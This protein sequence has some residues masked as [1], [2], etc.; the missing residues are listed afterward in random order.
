MKIVVAG[1]SGGIGKAFV[2]SL[3][4][5]PHVEKIIATCNSHC[6]ATDH[7]NVTWQRLNLADEAAVRDWAQQLDDIDW[8]I[9][10]AGVLHTPANGPEKTIRNLDP[11]FFLENMRINVLPTLLLAKYL[12]HRFRH[13]RRAIFASVSAKV[14][15][16]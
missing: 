11:A 4:L 16:I 10:A 1:G 3:S 6:P 14:G 9:N 8:L 15:S 2:K 5:R 12:H 13:G 7:R